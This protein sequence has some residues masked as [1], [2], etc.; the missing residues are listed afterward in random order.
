MSVNVYRDFYGMVAQL[1]FDWSKTDG[2][3]TVYPPFIAS[4]GTGHWTPTAPNPT[5]LFAPYW[6]LNRLFVQSSLNGTSSPLPPAYSTNLVVT[7]AA[8]F[9]A[10]GGVANDNCAVVYY[11][12]QDAPVTGS[13][14]MTVALNGVANSS[15]KGA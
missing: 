2:S 9:A 5:T 14:V 11:A 7:D 6:G 10:A 4:G 3:L 12:Y 13:C 1:I 15:S 8:A